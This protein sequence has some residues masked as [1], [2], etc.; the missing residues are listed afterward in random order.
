MPV[1]TF[2]NPKGGSGKSTACLL[3][4]LELARRQNTVSII[5]TDPL[6]WIGRWADLQPTSCQN[7]SVGSVLN[8]DKLPETIQNEIGSNDFVLID[9]EGSKNIAVAH[10]ITMADLVVIPIQPSALDSEA[11]A[12]A[13]NLLRAQEVAA[14]RRIPFVLVFNR[15]SAAIETRSGRAIRQEITSH[16]ISLLKV[17][18][19]ERAAFRELFAYGGDLADLPCD[20]VNGVKKAVDNATKYTEAVISMISEET[21]NAT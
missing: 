12:E 17:G 21:I 11:A 6:R 16:G 7:V 8:P 10:A 15:I 4:S 5:E 20:E 14:R 9:T 3:A 2:A 18:L 1:I 13:L 19:V